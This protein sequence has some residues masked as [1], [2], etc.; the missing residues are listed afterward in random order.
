MTRPQN[1][2]R[3]TSSPRLSST[4]P[5]SSP[6]CRAARDT[7]SNASSP[8]TVTVGG[9]TT[10]TARPGGRAVTTRPRS[11]VPAPPPASRGRPCPG[12]APDL[13]ARSPNE[14]AVGLAK[15]RGRSARWSATT[16]PPWKRG[17]AERARLSSSESTPVCDERGLDLVDRPG[18]MALAEERRRS[19]DVRRGH[20]RPGELRPAASGT[21]ERTSTPGAAT[22][23]FRR[24]EI[25]VGPTERSR[26]GRPLRRRSS[27][28]RRR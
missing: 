5:A 25:V 16:P 13:A 24:S 22:S 11:S 27:R 15:R 23:G 4:Y 28:P 17:P 12:S 3:R 21:D 20:A 7:R 9:T 8:G 26:R 2:T 19:C 6:L 18:R 14:S 1:G 10:R